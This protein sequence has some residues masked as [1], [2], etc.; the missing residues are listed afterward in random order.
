MKYVISGGNKLY[1][2]IKI[3][4][5]KNSVLCL[6]AASIL[7]SGGVYVKNCPKICDVLCMISILKSMGATVVEQD[8]GYYVNASNLTTL[9]IPE[10]LSNKVRA[11]LFLVGAI[12]GKYK[13]VY[14]SRTGGCNI[15]LRPMDIHIDA[16]IKL[17]ATVEEKNGV[18]HFCA[19][20]L[21]G[22]NIRLKYPSV[23]ATEN[24]IMS[25]CLADGVTVIENCAKEPEICDLANFINLMGGKVSGHGT[26]RITIIGVKKLAFAEFSPLPDRIETGTF[27]LLAAG[28]GGELEI[29]CTKWE[30][31]CILSEKLVNNSCK[32][33]LNNDIIYIQVNNRIKG[34]GQIETKPYPGFP[35]DLQPLLVSCASVA[36]GKTVVKETVFESR[37]AYADEL[38]KLGA[39]ISYSGNLLQV[40]GGK[41]FGAKVYSPDLRGGAGLCLAGLCAEGQTIIEN[42][43]TIERGYENFHKKLQLLGAKINKK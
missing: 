34:F 41:L 28:C 24:I 43:S 16:L 31:I 36:R 6:L 7:S 1:G 32:I 3:Q 21:K 39:K 38:K 8:G 29:K 22:A 12:L 2:S 14:I 26:S 11:S 13:E 20:Q 27:M 4:G 18:L 17:G 33:C 19:T 42:V 30:N 35:T 25:A 23:G 15:G 9:K 5:A 37:F 10:K 40:E